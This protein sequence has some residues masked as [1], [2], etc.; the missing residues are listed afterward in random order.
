[1]KRIILLTMAIASAPMGAFLAQEAKIDLEARERSIPIIEGRLRAR[2]A[3]IAE[4]GNDILEIHKRMDDKLGRMVDRLAALKDSVRTSHRVGNLKMEII[5]GLQEALDAFR[6]K[7]L[8]LSRDLEERRSGIPPE[9]INNEIRHIDT[10]TE[11]HIEQMLK[12]SKSFTQDKNVKKYESVS[13]DGSRGGNGGGGYGY[14]YGIDWYSDPIEISGDW[15]QNL[16]D[17]YMDKKQRDDVKGALDKSIDRCNSR[18]R[19]LSKDLEDKNLSE[20]DRKVI[21]SELDTHLSMLQR[22]QRQVE[23]LL[24]VENPDTKEITRD[25][26]D[27]LAGAVGDLMKDVDRDVRMLSFKHTQ[28]HDEESIAFKLKENLDARKKWLE[29]YKEKKSE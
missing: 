6:S 10:Q 26:A 8:A 28:L 17:R 22:R 14:G 13:A 21:Q 5:D 2:N 23:D 12:L 9:V 11:M 1:M 4:I 19:S 16:H 20:I 7:R 15:Q 29:E 18:I 3:Q 27:D 25:A 24:V